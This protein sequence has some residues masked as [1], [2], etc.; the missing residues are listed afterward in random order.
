M[1]MTI[2]HEAFFYIFGD[3]WGGMRDLTAQSILESRMEAEK[4]FPDQIC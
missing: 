1:Q 3:Q 2:C 4:V